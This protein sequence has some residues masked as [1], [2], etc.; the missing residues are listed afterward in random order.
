MTTRNA[1]IINAAMATTIPTMVPAA[2]P[3]LGK[4]FGISSKCKKTMYLVA[5]FKS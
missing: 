2:I 5:S 3:P 1:I 4:D